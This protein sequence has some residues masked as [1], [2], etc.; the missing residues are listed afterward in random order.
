MTVP[1]LPDDIMRMI[2]RH[3]AEL[4]WVNGVCLRVGLE[5]KSHPQNLNG[6]MRTAFLYPELSNTAMRVRL[7]DAIHFWGAYE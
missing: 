6:Y 1:Y 5:P 3:R 4:L 2:M 7:N